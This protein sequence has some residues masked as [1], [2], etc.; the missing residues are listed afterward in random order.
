M[1]YT[2]TSLHWATKEVG[3]KV[4][5]WIPQSW[6]HVESWDWV[7]SQHL[8]AGMVSPWNLSTLNP[9]WD[10]VKSQHLPM[11]MVSPWIPSTLNP[12]WDWV[13]SQHLPMGMVSPWIPSTLNPQWELRLRKTSTPAS[14]YGISMDSFNLEPMAMM[15]LS[16]I[17]TP[18]NGYAGTTGCTASW[19]H[20]KQL[21]WQTNKASPQI[22]STLN[23]WWRDCLKYHHINSCE[24]VYQCNHPAQ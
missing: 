17:S 15:R 20:T 1:V 11:G 12:S 19:Y 21:R 23:W 3:E 16:K 10:W 6:T 18:A 22:N 7:K 5:P 13:K 9:S 8:P 4:P 2:L 14:G 24:K